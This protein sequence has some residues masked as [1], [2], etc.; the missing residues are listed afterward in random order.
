MPVSTARIATLALIGALIVLRAVRIFSPQLGSAGTPREKATSQDASLRLSWLTLAAVVLA[1]AAVSHSAPDR[2]SPVSAPELPGGAS[3]DIA[4][5]GYPRVIN[6][7]TINIHGSRIRLFGIDAPEPHQTC[8]NASGQVF[9]CGWK[10]TVALVDHIAGGTVSCQARG[11][12]RF[13]R[14]V[15]VCHLGSED[16]N[17]W[18]VANGWAVAYRHHGLDYVSQENAAQ[19]E[20]LG[21]WAGSFILPWEWRRSH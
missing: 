12:D 2:T 17:A 3:P 19:A 4:A 9:D 20:K 8:K 7:D 21:I 1:S 11:V 13:G 16:L 18:M 5:S 14:A 6:G 15:A 10:A